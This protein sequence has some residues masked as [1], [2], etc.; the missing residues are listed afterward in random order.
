M[1]SKKLV[2]RETV[3]ETEKIKSKQGETKNTE[4]VATEQ[5][6]QLISARSVKAKVS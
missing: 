1:T 5:G 4:T 6:K 2:K 3:K